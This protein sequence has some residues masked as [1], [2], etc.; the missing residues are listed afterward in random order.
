MELEMGA[1]RDLFPVPV[2]RED[3]VEDGEDEVVQVG[4]D[5]VSELWTF[6]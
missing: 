5:V 4:V 2:S 3:N 6:G 1:Q